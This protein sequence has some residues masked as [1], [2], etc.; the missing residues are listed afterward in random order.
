MPK[1]NFARMIR[2]VDEFFETKNDPDQLS[3]DEEV[4]NRLHEVHPS[5]MGEIADE[6]GPVA[7]TIVIPTTA[8]V[9]KQFLNK[10]INEQALMDLTSPGQVF[11]SVYLCSALVLPEHRGKGLAKKLTVDSVRSIM[12]DHRI[13][14]LYYWAFS[15]EGDALANAA[16]FELGIPLRKRTP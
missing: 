7:W 1:D 13:T 9:M 11:E 3:I 4:M 6:D 12:L 14:T 2:L 15:K 16:S 10:E 5:T 8:S